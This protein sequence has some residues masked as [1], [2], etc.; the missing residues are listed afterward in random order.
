[1]STTEKITLGSGELFVMEFAGELPT[2]EEICL[3]ENR[4]GHVSGGATLEYTL[5][6][7]GEAGRYFWLP[8][9]REIFGDDMP[10]ITN[11]H[12][13]EPGTQ[14]EWF[15]D[16]ENFSSS[17]RMTDRKI[18]LRTGSTET[19]RVAVSTAACTS[20]YPTASYTA[21]K[22]E[23]AINATSSSCYLRAAQIDAEK[24]VSCLGGNYTENSNSVFSVPYFCI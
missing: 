5:L 1:M 23:D 13:D 16:W 18:T 3:P 14:I 9:A 4:L 6:T 2:T 24:A 19:V 12:S 10:E 22:T 7:Y 8:T 17:G 21:S 20:R 11:W 15:K